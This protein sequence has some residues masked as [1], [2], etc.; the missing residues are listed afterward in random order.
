MTPALQR[1]WAGGEDGASRSGGKQGL[2]LERIAEAAIAIADADG[3]G[4]VS[5]RSVSRRLGFTTMS[6]YRHVASKEELLAVMRDVALGPPPP[7]DLADGGWRG[8]LERWSQ[9]VVTQLLKHP[10]ALEVPITGPPTTP[11][12]IAWLD[13][14]LQALADAPLSESE[15]AGVILQLNGSAF[16]EARIAIEMGGGSGP[17]AAGRDELDAAVADYGAMLAGHVTA[18]RFPALQKALAAGIFEDDVDD[19]AFGRQL[20]LDGVERLLERRTR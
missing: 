1:L 17:H 4:A 16:W 6:I 15:K 7:L 19:F 2:S 13:M 3:L 10:W 18:E 20:T 9:G 5:M 14:G 12:A 8:A 11:G